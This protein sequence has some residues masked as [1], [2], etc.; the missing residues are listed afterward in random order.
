M[1]IQKG[2]L[3]QSALIVGVVILALTVLVTFYLHIRETNVNREEKRQ[4]KTMTDELDYKLIPIQNK[5][6]PDLIANPP[7]V[8]PIITN[9][10]R[11]RC[12][13]NVCKKFEDKIYA[14]RGCEY[15]QAQGMCYSKPQ[16]S[17]VKCSDRDLLKG[18][19]ENYGSETVSGHYVRPIPP[20][21][22]FCRI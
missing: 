9:S 8:A 2:Q 21:R 22:N 15:C 10:C 13:L 4:I 19:E 1:K 7:S 11:E 12:G 16:D 3:L 5:I 20:E 18:C 6:I 14:Y 17:C